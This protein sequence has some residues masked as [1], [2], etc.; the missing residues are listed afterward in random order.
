MI[1]YASRTGTKRNLNAL[2]ARDWRLMLSAKGRLN[3]LEGDWKY[4]LDN[5]AWYAFQNGEA[6]D[7][8]AFGTAL[9][10]FGEGADFIVAPDI[11]AAGMR[12]FDFSVA[13]LPRLQG[14]APIA[15]AVQDG[16]TIADVEPL[17]AAGL[18][19]V[20]FVGG[21]TEW[22]IA[23]MADWVALGLRYGIPT[24]IG[25]V[26]TIKRIYLCLAAGAHSFDGSGPGKFVECLLTID[27]ARHQ[28]DLEAHLRRT[29]A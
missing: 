8:A 2:K 15:F 5:G 21:S 19:Q 6:F 20:L 28:S 26:N 29:A 12:S 22:K 14:A 13:W 3:P 16:M 25:R 24:H 23:T 10:L 4:A 18:V 1:A 9:D 11:V 7:E 17:L 27:A